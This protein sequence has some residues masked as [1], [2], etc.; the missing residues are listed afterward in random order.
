VSVVTQQVVSCSCQLSIDLH[1]AGE[2]QPP[3]M[4]IFSRLRQG[5]SAS[6]P[7]LDRPDV[8][9]LPSWDEKR[10]WSSNQGNSMR[11]DPSRMASEPLSAASPTLDDQ[12]A[13]SFKLNVNALDTMTEAIDRA[14]DHSSQNTDTI[15]DF[16]PSTTMNRQRMPSEGDESPKKVTF[17][18]PAPTPSPLESATILHLG[19]PIR[20]QD[21]L[22][23]LSSQIQGPSRR[24]VTL[25]SPRL[26][27]SR[28]P[29]A[30]SAFRAALTFQARS[31]FNRRSNMPPING[32]PLTS[33]PDPL[34]SS[35]SKLAYSPIPSDAASARSYIPPPNS[36]SEMADHDLIANLGPRERARQEVLWEIVSSE[37]RWVELCFS[38]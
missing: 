13:S 34:A 25:P 12:P 5:T 14:T 6:K 2:R 18:S 32:A 35:P 36:W 7:S 26:S 10:P 4:G 11:R 37:E 24:S 3:L 23:D 30:Q 1:R 9:A 16:S 15:P 20:V 28:A 38:V 31:A 19:P 22:S 33:S 17:V 29:S 21:S 27:N 8:H